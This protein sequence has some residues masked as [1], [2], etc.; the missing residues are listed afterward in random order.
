MTRILQFYLPSNTSHTRFYSHLHSITAHWLVFTA[1]IHGG[2]DRLSWLGLV[3]HTDMNFP[4]PGVESPIPCV[5]CK[6]KFNNIPKQVICNRRMSDQLTIV[7]LLRWPPHDAVVHTILNGQHSH[8]LVLRHATQQ[9]LHQ[10][11]AETMH[12]STVSHVSTSC[13]QRAVFSLIIICNAF[14]HNSSQ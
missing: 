7:H 1:P 3:L 13:Q 11:H 10:C 5:K 4:T 14:Y 12:A 6:H 8:Q 9:A 2:M